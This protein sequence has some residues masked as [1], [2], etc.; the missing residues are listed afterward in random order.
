MVVLDRVL[1][2]CFHQ[3]ILMGS[4]SSHKVMHVKRSDGSLAVRVDAFVVIWETLPVYMW[5]ARTA[6][7]PLIRPVLEVGYDAFLAIRP[8]LPRRR[9]NEV[10]CD[11]SSGRLSVWKMTAIYLN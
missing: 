1:F 5:L 8:Y 9:A 10:Q 11:T 7:F 4:G 3:F 6:R 2:I